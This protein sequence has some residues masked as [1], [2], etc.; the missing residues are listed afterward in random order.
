MRK[1]GRNWN[2]KQQGEGNRKEKEG[3]GIREWRM[4]FQGKK[5][6]KMQDRGEERERI[7]SKV[8][9]MVG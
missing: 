4:S 2:K 1:Q 3:R 6:I 5:W 9:E 8:G 7:E